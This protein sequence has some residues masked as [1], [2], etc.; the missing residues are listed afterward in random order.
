GLASRVALRHASRRAAAVAPLSLLTAPGC[1]SPRCPKAAPALPIAPR[2]QGRRK[3]SRCPPFYALRRAAARRARLLFLAPRSRNVPSRSA[4]RPW[5]SVASS[6]AELALRRSALA[7][8]DQL[9][10]G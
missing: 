8:G 7:W 10:T 3:S 1:Q 4:C 9:P 6:A 5:R 2:L